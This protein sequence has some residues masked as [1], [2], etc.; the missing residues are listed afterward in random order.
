MM[1]SWYAPLIGKIE[2]TYSDLVIVADGD[3]LGRD[4]AIRR[5]LEEH[6]AL[7]D[8]RGELPLRAFLDDRDARR[9]VAIFNCGQSIFSTWWAA[10]LRFTGSPNTFFGCTVTANRLILPFCSRKWSADSGT[11]TWSTDQCAPF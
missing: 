7:H 4:T 2:Q 8:Y 5:A 1:Q 6:F 11:M 10:L 3:S 9:R